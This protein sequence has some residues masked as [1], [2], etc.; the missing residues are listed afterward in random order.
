MHQ[1]TR[2]H[3]QFGCHI[4]SV[5]DSDKMLILLDSKVWVRLW[6]R[7]LHGFGLFSNICQELSLNYVAC[8]FFLCFV[9]LP[10]WTGVK[11]RDLSFYFYEQG[12][13]WG[14]CPSTCIYRGEIEGFVLLPVWTGVRVRD[15]SFYLYMNRGES[16]GFVLY[17]HEQGWKWGICPSTC[18]NRSEG[19][20]IIV[21]QCNHSESRQCLHWFSW[22]L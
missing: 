9:P 19:C 1:V 12:W 17:L 3:F 10:V 11:V 22:D 15:L 7:L 20:V 13:K 16:E 5:D 8:S 4:I 18:M 14:I 6:E 21:N 2:I